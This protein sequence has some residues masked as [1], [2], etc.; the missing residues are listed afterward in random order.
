MIG[1]ESNSIRVPCTSVLD[2]RQASAI[3][4]PWQGKRC[5]AIDVNASSDVAE[6]TRQEIGTYVIVI[7]AT[8]TQTRRTLSASRFNKDS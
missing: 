2:A 3:I 6:E 1:E 4:K 7:S 8:G 5:K